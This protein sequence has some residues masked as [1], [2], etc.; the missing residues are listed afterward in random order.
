MRRQAGAVR[1]H[2]EHRLLR[3]MQLGEQ[4]RHRCRRASI[5]VSRRLVAEEQR[6][7][8]NQGARDCDA[9]ALAARELAGS[10]IH[11]A[12]KP[13]FGEQRSRA[14][15]QL[16]CGRSVP[17]DHRGHEDVVERGQLRQKK[18]ILEHE[19]H[20]PVPKHR[21][22]RVVEGVRID[23][24]HAN[25]ARGW[26][27]ERA[28]DV[29]QRALA[30]AGRSHDRDGLPALDRERDVLQDWQRTPWRVVLLGNR[31]G[32]EHIGYA[33]AGLVRSSPYT[34]SAASAM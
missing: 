13:D 30:A 18:M 4:C 34:F 1:D 12:L 32:D 27:L 21:L 14:R 10:M 22:T 23:I 31:V 20:V 6:R 7:F 8:E 24:V 15:R 2:H 16:A 3:V 33:R 26:R 28:E 5:E 9:L 17:R 25:R 19:A 11:A 29:Q